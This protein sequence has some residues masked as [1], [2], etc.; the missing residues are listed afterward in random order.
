MLQCPQHGNFL[1]VYYGGD[2]PPQ[3]IGRSIHTIREIRE[4]SVCVR[5]DNAQHKK[6]KHMIFYVKILNQ[7][8][9]QGRGGEFTII[10]RL[11]E[12]RK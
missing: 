4:S 9:P 11:Q 3:A 2:F 10:H 7:E 12:L 5:Q 1:D 6:E 8:K